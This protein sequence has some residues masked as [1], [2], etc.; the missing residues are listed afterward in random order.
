MIKLSNYALLDIPNTS[1]SDDY[2][3]DN[4]D[5]YTIN[6]FNF[7]NILGNYAYI[8]GLIG[9]N[10]SFVSLDAKSLIPLSLQSYALNMETSILTSDDYNPTSQTTIAE[11]VFWKW[12]KESGA[13][14]WN[15][16]GN[17]LTECDNLT[18]PDNTDL[19]KRVVK[20]LGEITSS[21][22]KS[23]TFGNFNEV[24]IQIPSSF[25]TTPVKFKE[26]RDENY[27]YEKQ[28]HADGN[29]LVLGQ[30]TESN[31]VL[32]SVAFYDYLGSETTVMRSI[33]ANSHNLTYNKAGFV[34]NPNETK[35]GWWYTAQGIVP[36][37]AK[38]YIIDKQ[39]S[40]N[41]ENIHL[42]IGDKRILRSNY[43]CMSIN[44]D[45]NAYSEYNVK[46]FEEL[47]IL[48][49]AE[50]YEFNAVLL[51]YTVYD[52]TGTTKLAT[53][54]LGVLFIDGAEGV[55]SAESKDVVGDF[56]HIPTLEKVKSRST[57]NFGNSYNFRVNIQSNNLKDD[58]AACILDSTSLNYLDDFTKVFGNL[59][60]AVYILGKQSKTID[61]ISK[62]YIQINNV[63]FDLN[64]K[65]LSLQQ[66]VNGIAESL[67]IDILGVK[68]PTIK[69]GKNIAN[70]AKSSSNSTV[71]GFH[72]C[73]KAKSLNNTVAIGAYS[74][75]NC[76]LNDGGVYIGY[77]AGYNELKPNMLH[78]ESNERFIN[79]SL[80]SGNFDTRE[81]TFNA[82]K[83]FLPNISNNVGSGIAV[84]WDKGE[85]KLATSSRRYKHA[86]MDININ[87]NVS[88]VIELLEPVSF[89]YINSTD[90]S[91]GLIAEEVEKIDKNLVVY[92]EEG[93]PNGVKYDML[94]VL[95]LN[96]IKQLNNKINSIVGH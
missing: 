74:G 11:R 30:T 76:E 19:Y 54:L 53:N 80:I 90:I 94:S 4:N 26:V 81:L 38:S 37:N 96:E 48:D 13:I 31:N 6:H 49:S 77:K 28:F 85:L 23:N 89:K 62:Q 95:L 67:N 7:H 1:P 27:D 39:V 58:T 36:T 92:D 45:I 71:V 41:E 55:I 72:S 83:L 33:K 73:Y 44:F 82:R 22:F 65:Y 78:I 5:N 68:S 52:K 50:D 70:E 79:E 20:G 40:N 21:A 64:N 25:G 57:Q 12:L 87:T 56:F 86:I 93:K 15:K 34:D 35:S 17:D 75:Y 46:S 69:I 24:L 14:R 61:F 2:T 51:Y 84:T 63:A 32:P 42:Q 29:N 91:Y 43:D 18:S 60:Q 59:N 10:N 9:G 88:R 66:T 3:V 8:N 47:A 16:Q